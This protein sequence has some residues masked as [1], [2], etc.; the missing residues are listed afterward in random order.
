[1]SA[2]EA[3]LITTGECHLCDHAHRVLDALDGEYAFRLREVDW[4]SEQGQALVVP[5]GVAFP[6]A[7]YVDGELV[8][9]GRLSE[10]SLRRRLAGRARP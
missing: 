8:A 9:Y 3:V 6:P 10:R 2:I 4:E 1:M 7:L 5:D